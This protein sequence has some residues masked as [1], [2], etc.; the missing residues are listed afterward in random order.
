M[1]KINL[2]LRIIFMSA[3]SIGISMA[4][5]ARDFDS[6]SREY[7]QKLNARYYLDN[8]NPFPESYRNEN[9]EMQGIIPPGEREAE[10]ALNLEF[11]HEGREVKL[12]AGGVS[13]TAYKPTLIETGS[14]VYHALCLL[15]TGNELDAKLIL[16]EAGR[17]FEKELGIYAREIQ[18][19]SDY[20]EQTMKAR[21]RAAEDFRIISEISSLTARNPRDR[22]QINAMA[23]AISNYLDADIGKTIDELRRIHSTRSSTSLV[24]I[25]RTV[26]V[27]MVPNTGVFTRIVKVQSTTGHCTGGFVGPNLVLTNLHCLR[28][29]PLA[30]IRDHYHYRD[31]WPVVEVHTYRGRDDAYKWDDARDRLKVR[32]GQDWAILKIGGQRADKT[33]FFFVSREA[34][35]DEIIVAGYSADVAK[36]NILTADLPC[37]I[38]APE[39]AAMIDYDCS[40]F[41]GSSGSPIIAIRDLRFILGVHNSGVQLSDGGNRLQRRPAAGVAATQFFTTLMKL[42]P[43]DVTQSYP[44]IG[45]ARREFSHIKTRSRLQKATSN[46]LGDW[47]R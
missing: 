13:F 33:N 18:Q 2:F 15:N 28:G 44:I 17:K 38:L 10:K 4:V 9:C 40:T 6:I 45:D 43:R 27:P 24:E 20:A 47:S 37:T 29:G 8:S 25:E 46:Q 35:Q 7:F 36:G 32:S 19:A 30:V 1:I 41:G 23:G 21:K 11:F 5:S 26:R 39:S 16:K 3:A 42:L 31:V 14:L 22:V 34:R 12:Q